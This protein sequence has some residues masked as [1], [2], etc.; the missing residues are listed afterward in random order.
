MSGISAGDA[1]IMVS[2]GWVDLAVHNRSD[3]NRGNFWCEMCGRRMAIKEIISGYHYDKNGKT[4]G[5]CMNCWRKVN[6]RR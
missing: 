4:F 1:I 3:M 5:K 6:E 2:G